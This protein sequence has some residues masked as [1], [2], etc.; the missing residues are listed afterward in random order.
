MP[1]QLLIVEDDSDSLEMLA[2]LLESYGFGVAVAPRNKIARAE[3]ERAGFDLVIADLM[4]DSRDPA[5]SW[6]HIDALVELAKPSPIGLL[7]SW[8]V[9]EEQIAQHGLAF[10]LAKP[11]TS[12]VLLDRVGSILALPRLSAEQEQTIRSY[13]AH[14]EAREFDALVEVCTEDVVYRLPSSG[15][16]IEGRAAFRAYTVQTFERFA[17]A[18]FELHEIRPLPRGAVAHYTGTWFDGD[19]KKSLGGAVLFVLEGARICEIGVRVDLTRAQELS[20]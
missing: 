16:T 2:L 19:Q 9:K 6:Q 7:T 5:V 15:E 14:L 3:L 17:G 1:P 10:A 8:P 12:E 11:C 18:T 13:F 4:V 20:S